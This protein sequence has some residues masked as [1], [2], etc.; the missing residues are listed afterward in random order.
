MSSW[1]LIINKQVGQWGT[2]YSQGQDLARIPMKVSQRS[3][4][5]ETFTISFDKT[6]GNSATLKLDWE[7]TTASV[8]VKEAK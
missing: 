1:Q 7:N 6:G 3:S 5:M 4:G 8:D 2:E